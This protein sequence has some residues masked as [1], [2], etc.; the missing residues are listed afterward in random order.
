MSTTLLEAFTISGH[1]LFPARLF[2]RLLSGKPGAVHDLDFIDLPRVR[3]KC[4]DLVHRDPTPFSRAGKFGCM[5]SLAVFR[6]FPN[7]ACSDRITKSLRAI[8]NRGVDGSIGSRAR[9]LKLKDFKP[10]F[11]SG[12]VKDLVVVV[13]KP[14][15]I[16][17]RGCAKK[18]TIKW[19]YNCAGDAKAFR[20]SKDKDVCTAGS[21]T[22]NGNRSGLMQI[23]LYF[24][25]YE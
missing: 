6:A 10:S 7:D 18:I 2:S 4:A 3:S 17:D 20:S 13:P 25:R 24:G 8:E 16:Q 21:S 1:F 14:R 22:E 23:S 9:L 19:Q 11:R 12:A 5:V 15:P